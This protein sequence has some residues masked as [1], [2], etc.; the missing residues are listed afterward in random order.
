MYASVLR[1]EAIR[2][3]PAR[4]RAEGR[5][6]IA[7][8]RHGPATRASRVAEAGSLRVRMPRVPGPTLEAVLINTGGGIA[9]GDR[10]S[11]DVSVGE[12][13]ELMLTTPAAERAYSSDGPTATIDV[14]LSLADHASL[15]WLPQE[16]ILFDRARLR[17]SL[18]A[19]IGPSAQ[20]LLFA[21]FVFGRSARGERVAQGFLEDR[22]RIRRGGELI[23]AETLRLSGPIDALLERPAIAGGAR[24]FAS[25]VYVAPDAESRLEE[26]RAILGGASG[27]CGASAWNGLLAV[28]FLAAEIESLRRDA[29]H[30]LTAFRGRPLPRVWQS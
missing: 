25:L 10:F 16:T 29:M 7:A 18:D 20:L 17:A 4:Q 27:Q 1:S 28:R 5:V 8:T 11:V 21:A 15:A 24:A 19:E 14:R 6:A 3:A 13:A 12:G 26:A 9:C 23:L 30:L 2:C 22:W